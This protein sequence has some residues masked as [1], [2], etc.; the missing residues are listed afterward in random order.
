MTY[1]G[2]SNQYTCSFTMKSGNLS[3]KGIIESLDIDISCAYDLTAIFNKYTGKSNIT[4]NVCGRT[5]NYNF[6]INVK[7]FSVPMFFPSFRNQILYDNDNG[8]NDFTISIESI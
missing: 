4:G 7:N 2:Y 6:K 8:E 1:A 5:V 3:A